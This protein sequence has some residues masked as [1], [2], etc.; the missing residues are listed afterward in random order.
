MKK[1]I[2]YSSTENC[3]VD[4]LSKETAH[5]IMG[6]L[7]N[8]NLIDG[9]FRFVNNGNYHIETSKDIYNNLVLNR[10]EFSFDSTFIIK[11]ELVFYYP[12]IDKYVRISG[13]LND[14][15]FNALKYKT[16]VFNFL[17]FKA[18]PSNDSYVIVIDSAG[19]VISGKDRFYDIDIKTAID[20]YSGRKIWE[21]FQLDEGDQ[22]R[23]LINSMDGALV[24]VSGIYKY[25]K[26][27]N[28]YF[29]YLIKEN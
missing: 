21:I 19:N 1:L 18:S 24:E 6:Q 11:R 3:K 10:N 20:N 22:F 7:G 12:V 9:N 27:L 15:V 29:I 23:F 13:S 26:D 17:N 14:Y 2:L 5:F 28:L 25:E 8:K 4:I 16:Q